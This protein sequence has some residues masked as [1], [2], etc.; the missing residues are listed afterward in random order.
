M[1]RH[2][3]LNEK[4]LKVV[5]EVFKDHIRSVEASLAVCNASREINSD[6]FKLEKELIDIRN[7]LNQ[8]YKDIND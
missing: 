4:Q 3:K 7:E 8:L 6:F 5:I 1:L 2:S